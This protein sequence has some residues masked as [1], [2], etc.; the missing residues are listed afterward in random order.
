M[1]IWTSHRHQHRGL[2]MLNSCVSQCRET[3]SCASNVE[4][5]TSSAHSLSVCPVKT[6]RIRLRYY[7]FKLTVFLQWFVLFCSLCLCFCITFF[8]QSFSETWIA[9][10]LLYVSNFIYLWC[11]QCRQARVVQGLLLL[12]TLA[13]HCLELESNSKQSNITLWVLMCL[14]AEK[15]DKISYFIVRIVLSPGCT[16]Y[17]LSSVIRM[18]ILN[19][20][21]PQ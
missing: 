11:T 15:G 3:L 13:R 14:M 18:N 19:S 6:H 7:S 1:F 9:I 5:L 17:L 21:L 12:N 2:A 8:H 16:M 20:L 4:S 10:F